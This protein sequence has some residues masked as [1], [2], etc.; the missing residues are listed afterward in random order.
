MWTQAHGSLTPAL[1]A[2]PHFKLPKRRQENAPSSPLPDWSPSGPQPQSHKATFLERVTQV[3]RLVQAETRMLGGHA[4]TGA[5]RLRQSS[6][7]GGPS[8][9]SGSKRLVSMGLACPGRSPAGGV[10]LP[11]APGCAPGWGSS[12]CPRRGQ[13]GAVIKDEEEEGRSRRVATGTCDMA[14]LASRWRPRRPR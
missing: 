14:V 3:E 2:P 7:G 1:P 6:S 11:L 12:R 8:F 9:K 5:A 10:L 4:P 13:A